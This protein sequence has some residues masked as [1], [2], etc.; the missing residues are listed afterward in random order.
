MLI[1]SIFLISNKNHRK[2]KQKTK[3]KISVRIEIIKKI[4]IRNFPIH[5]YQI[6]RFLHPLKQYSV[7]KPNLPIPS[8]W[9][10]TT[11]DD[12][13]SQTSK[14]LQTRPTNMATKVQF[15]PIW[16]LAPHPTIIPSTSTFNVKFTRTLF[17]DATDRIF[18]FKA[19]T[20]V[21][22]NFN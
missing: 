3:T 14:I 6:L 13:T 5:S 20:D 12:Q 19:W 11:H 17:V 10:I 8:R 4:I 9:V 22:K 16:P 7:S 18:F 21:G 15:E 1:N 2:M